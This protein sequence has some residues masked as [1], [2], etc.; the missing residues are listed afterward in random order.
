MSQTEPVTA[1]KEFKRN[2]QKFMF[3]TNTLIIVLIVIV[4]AVIINLLAVRYSYRMDLTRNKMYS[5]SD[6]T[7]QA[8]KDLNKQNQT[9]KIYG[10]FATGDRNQETVRDLLKQY[11]KRSNKISFEF[12]DPN[13]N[14]AQATKY[15]VQELSTLV[16]IMGDQQLK[17]GPSDLFQQSYYGQGTF[18]GEQAISR[19]IYKMI[20]ADVKKIYM[21]TGHGEKSYMQAETYLMGQGF[22]VKTGDLLKDGKIADDC[23]LLAIA[24]P[25]GDLTG[26]EVKLLEEYLSQGGRVMIL[27]DYDSRKPAL[28]N[29]KSLIRAWGIEVTDNLVVELERANLFDPTNIIPNFQSHEI[30]NPLQQNNMNVILPVNRELKK[31]EKAEVTVSVLLESSA[32]SWAETNPSAKGVKQDPGE[33]KGPIPLGM[34]ASRFYN[35]E[36]NQKEGR[37]IVI[38]T[39][40]FLNNNF[41]GQ[42]GNL[43]F[44]YNMTQWLLGQE[45]RV[46]I[47]P[48]Q[49]DI[50]QISLTPVQ[51]GLIRLMVLIV[52][53][54]LILGLGAFIW[55]R[56]RAR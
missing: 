40:L 51:A 20:D 52:L 41:I 33:T 29:L 13:R 1:Q 21:M 54:L 6:Q 11:Q 46:S 31:L 7:I 26:P 15:Q 8:L 19:S 24:G 27:L 23:A 4:L 10:F 45:D 2:L 12:I 44:L 3:N 5:L 47:T 49:S 34:A 38:G 16:L 30:T 35:Y 55:I 37:M 43:N 25:K 36:G 53:P 9:I 28:P 18:M 50:T 22:E 32:R 48:K 39:S 42:A 56:R 14:P 17:L